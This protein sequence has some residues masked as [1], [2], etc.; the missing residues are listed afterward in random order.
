MLFTKQKCDSE[1]VEGEDAL[2]TSPL[3]PLFLVKS[4]LPFKGTEK[5]LREE[6]LPLQRPL[7]QQRSEGIEIGEG[8]EIHLSD[9][10]Y[11]VPAPS[12]ALPPLSFPPARKLPHFYTDPGGELSPRFEA[13]LRSAP[14]ILA[15]EIHKKADD[16]LDSRL[17][18]SRLIR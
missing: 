18:F 2:V 12:P 16:A 7:A 4:D 14:S 10:D 15:S 1:A 9:P 17:L 11:K 13:T 8:E 6:S 5:L 3:L